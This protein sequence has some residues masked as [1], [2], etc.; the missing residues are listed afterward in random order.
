[1]YNLKAP[2]SGGV[3]RGAGGWD[4]QNAWRRHRGHHCGNLKGRPAN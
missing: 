1:M 2:S 3:S 4:Y